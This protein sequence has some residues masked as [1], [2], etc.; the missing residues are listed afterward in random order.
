MEF[1][2]NREKIRRNAAAQNTRIRVYH[3][4]IYHVAGV[5]DANAFL[6]GARCFKTPQA[7]QAG[8]PA[9]RSGR[10]SWRPVLA[11]RRREAAFAAAGVHGNVE[12]VTMD[13]LAALA[14]TANPSGHP[15]L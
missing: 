14:M 2:L 7:S 11:H 1:D 12:D 3:G 6:T 15:M 10:N 13:C 4:R 8:L 5:G 9:A